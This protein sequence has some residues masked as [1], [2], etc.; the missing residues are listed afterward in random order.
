VKILYRGF[1][2]LGVAMCLESSSW[3]FK[4]F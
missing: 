3:H 2:I 4:E 1:V